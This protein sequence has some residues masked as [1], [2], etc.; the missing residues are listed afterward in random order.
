MTI[1][2]IL[3]IER[4]SFFQ[5]KEFFHISILVMLY[6][7]ILASSI[8]GL[9]L[10]LLNPV[11]EPRVLMGFSALLCGSGLTLWKQ[12][13]QNEEF[14]IF[15][16][17]STTILAIL[18]INIS[19]T[20]GNVVSAQTFYNQTTASRLLID[21]KT[22]TTNELMSSEES[23]IFILGE[24]DDASP[25]VK[26]A[27]RKYPFMKE[28]LPSYFRHWFHSY[29]LLKSQGMEHKP[30][31]LYRD[32]LNER[33]V[34]NEFTEKTEAI[35]SAEDYNIYLFDENIFIVKFEQR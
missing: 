24:M 19:L 8:G 1:K 31:Y 28:M 18:F 35:L 27:R 23:K 25:L 32:S 13:K 21:L 17:V 26:V 10:L 12:I 15:T 14:K 29:Q 20:Y 22:A 16:I 4:S 11:W 6:G 30:T 7:F 34:A 3:K 33:Q 5:A 2:T 9:N